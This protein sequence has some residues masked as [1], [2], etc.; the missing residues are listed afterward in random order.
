MRNLRIDGDRLWA[1]LMEIG[2]IGETP[3]GGCRRLALTDLDRQARDL[4][5]R[6]ARDAGCTISVDAIGNIFAR[7]PG[8]DDSLPPVMVGSHLDTVPTGGKFDGILG[9]MTGLEILRTLHDREM[10]T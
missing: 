1:S 10:V 5:C 9:V 3:A 7:R 8:R 6:W 4:F 2:K